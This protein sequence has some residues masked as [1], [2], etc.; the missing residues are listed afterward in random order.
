MRGPIE[1]RDLG[2]CA[3]EH[4]LRV[5]ESVWEARRS[6]GPDVCLALQHPPTVTFGRRATDADLRRPRT[7]LAARGIACVTTERGGRATYHGPGQLVVYPIV[8]LRARGIGVS[9]FVE[10]LETI[11]IEVAARCGVRAWRDERGHGIWAAGGKLGAVG[12]R[13]RD[14]LSTHGLAL[15]V[16]VD[17]GAYDVIV[18]CGLPNEPVT[19]L[20]R[21]GGTATMALVLPAMRAA[22]ERRLSGAAVEAGAEVAL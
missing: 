10:I 16:D 8:D 14:H 11:M 2:P 5:Q 13:V 3:Y 15:N 6:G 1:W 4:G 22:C 19:S 7:E 20:A 17:L 18:P 21:E 9:M 12:I